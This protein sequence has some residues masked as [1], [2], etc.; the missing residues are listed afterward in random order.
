M[1][2]MYLFI[3]NS[4]KYLLKNCVKSLQGAKLLQK[5]MFAKFE[6]L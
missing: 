3:W 5:I 6:N 2:N 4:V 1:I